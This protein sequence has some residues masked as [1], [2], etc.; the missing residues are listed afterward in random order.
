MP[1]NEVIETSI[2]FNYCF[3]APAI[4]FATRTE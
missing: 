3:Y 4:P 1:M 2:S